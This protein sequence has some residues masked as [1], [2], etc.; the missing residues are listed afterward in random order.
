MMLKVTGENGY[1]QI[2]RGK[3]KKA[4]YGKFR[5]LM[6]LLPAGCYSVVECTG[7][8]DKR[9]FDYDKASLG[10]GLRDSLYPSPWLSKRVRGNIINGVFN[11][12]GGG[13]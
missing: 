6:G 12:I 8:G 7:R 13:R 11:T 1:K 4:L 5:T 10:S 9:L 2:I 3:T